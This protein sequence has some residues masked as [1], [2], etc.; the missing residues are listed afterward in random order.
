[1]ILDPSTK[2]EVVF[3]EDKIL[4]CLIL[5]RVSFSSF[6]LKL[7]MFFLFFEKDKSSNIPS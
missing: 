6:F 3:E 7:K 2:T 1:M 5:I 4:A